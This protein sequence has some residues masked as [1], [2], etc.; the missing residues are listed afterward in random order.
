MPAGVISYPIQAYPNV[1]DVAA[2]IIIF[3]NNNINSSYVSEKSISSTVPDWALNKS[4]EPVSSNH[5]VSSVLTFNYH[6]VDFCLVSYVREEEGVQ[7]QA[8]LRIYA[9]HPATNGVATERCCYVNSGDS[10]TA[11]NF[12]LAQSDLYFVFRQTGESTNG[13]YAVFKVDAPTNPADTNAYISVIPNSAYFT[14]AF[15]GEDITTRAYLVSDIGEV[16]GYTSGA[17]YDSNFVRNIYNNKIPIYNVY[18]HSRIYGVRGKITSLAMLP[19]SY[20]T[21]SSN[22]Y[23]I[24]GIE[25]VGLGGLNGAINSSYKGILLRVV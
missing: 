12:L 16:S 17:A 22:L 19:N 6:S 7:S 2:G 21:S 3:L 13:Y 18:A 14:Q 20:S 4:N 9:K 5:S 11:W 25:Y 10:S 23:S 15:V 8:K 1:W 24:N